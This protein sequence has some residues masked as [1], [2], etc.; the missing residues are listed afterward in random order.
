VIDIDLLG[1]FNTTK[2]C[3]EELKKTQGRLLYISTTLHYRGT[4]LQTHVT[5][6]KAGIDALNTQMC[7]EY[8]PRGITSN[9]IAPG[10]IKGTEGLS[11]LNK[12][13]STDNSP[14]GIPLQ[15][16][17]TV[18]DIAD[19]TIFLFSPAAKYISGTIIQVDGGAC[20]LNNVVDS[21]L[22]YPE[23]VLSTRPVGGVGA[24]K[25]INRGKL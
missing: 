4:P 14:K 22:P 23:S 21:G 9:V 2:A 13:K 1:S 11:R 3:A 10:G 5:A 19:A 18:A 7:I 12:S 6:A 25:S 15:R 24:K 8:G 17:G 16:W 20:H